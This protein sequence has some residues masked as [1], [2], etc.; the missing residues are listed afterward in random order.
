SAKYVELSVEC[1]RTRVRFPPPPP[2]HNENSPAGASQRGCSRCAVLFRR[3]ESNPRTVR[4]RGEWGFRAAQQRA[5]ERRCASG[6]N[7]SPIRLT[8]ENRAAIFYSRASDIYLGA[9]PPFQ[10]A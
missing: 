10:R 8:K 7:G 3:R 5:H 1:L 2:P 9:P 4:T 6:R